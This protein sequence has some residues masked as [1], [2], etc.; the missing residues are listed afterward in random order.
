MKNKEKSIKSLRD[1]RN[2]AESNYN[3]L[4]SYWHRTHSLLYSKDSHPHHVPADNCFHK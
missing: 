2:S 3:N 1:G 4:L